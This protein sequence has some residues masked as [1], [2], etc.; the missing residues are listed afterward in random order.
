MFPA[1]QPAAIQRPSAEPPADF[2]YSNK[3]SHKS[4]TSLPEF[5]VEDNQKP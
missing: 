1:V 4:F 2:G 3:T 5:R